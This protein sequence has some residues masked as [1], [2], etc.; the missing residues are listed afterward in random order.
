MIDAEVSLMASHR[1]QRFQISAEG[2]AYLPEAERLF[3][4][5]WAD[6]RGEGARLQERDRAGALL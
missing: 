3:V 6:D 2:G 1:R 4:F 5:Y